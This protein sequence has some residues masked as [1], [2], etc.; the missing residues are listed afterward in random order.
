MDA[1]EIA[2]LLGRASTDP[3]IDA[4][5]TR[6]GID[7]RPRVKIDDED[8]DGPVVE[9]QDWVINNAVGIEF[10]FDD[11]ASWHGLDEFERGRHPMLLTQ[12]YFYCDHEE[13]HS[14]PGPLPFGLKLSDNRRAVR[15]RMAAVES[16]RRSYIRDTWELRDF[17]M[18]VSYVDD[19]ARIDFV[20]CMLRELPL[21]PFDYS[22][23]PAPTIEAVVGLLGKGCNDPAFREVFA[24]LGF[25]RH[26][27]DVRQGG[28][29][30]FR[31]TYGFELGFSKPSATDQGPAG[32]ASEPIFSHGV[33]YRERELDARGWQGTLPL[34]ILFE[35]SPEIAIGKVGGSPDEQEDGEFTGYAL[36][37]LPDYSLHLYYSTIE[38][39]I[40]RLRVMAPGVWEA[41][42]TE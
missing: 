19:D 29:A 25:D 4:E 22:L 5:L 26:L 39:L 12:I 38:N 11:E 36:W 33:F 37:H 34:G 10:G 9:V 1:S 23:L 24:P 40:L 28:G 8:P 31:N 42:R 17:T 13:V 16:T 2:V 27:D 20:L 35:D 3:R 32:S 6:F 41:Y 14:Y 7:D 21:P 30:D 18:T 15:A